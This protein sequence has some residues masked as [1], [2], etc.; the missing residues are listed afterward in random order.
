MNEL[1]NIT[2]VGVSAIA[3]WLVYR[4]ASEFFPKHTQALHELA[5]AIQELK[6]HMGK[7]DKTHDANFHSVGP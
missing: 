1:T 5:N 2:G 3:L 4:L 6:A 7:C